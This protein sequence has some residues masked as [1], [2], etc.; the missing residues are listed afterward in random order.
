M[1]KEFVLNLMTLSR[2]GG[3]PGQSEDEG[4]AGEPK[5]EWGLKTSAMLMM[6]FHFRYHLKLYNKLK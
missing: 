1:K 4:A 6:I 2:P 5:K 3:A